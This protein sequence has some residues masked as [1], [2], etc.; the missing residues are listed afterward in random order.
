MKRLINLS[1]KFLAALI[2]TVTAAACVHQFPDE[3]TPADF[4]LKLKFNIEIG[5]NVN[6][7]MNTEINTGIG[8]GTKVSSETHDIRYIV[9]FFRLVNGEMAAEPAYEHTFTID[10]INIHTFEENLEI[11]EGHYRIYV[12]GDYVEQ[13][14]IDDHHYKTDGFPKIELMVSEDGGYEGSMESRDAYVGYTDIDVVR[15]GSTEKPVEA[16]VDIHRPLAKFVVI[17]NDLE[18]F[19]TKITQERAAELRQQAVA[20][21]ITEEAAE[22]ALTK[23]VDLD[24]FDVRFHFMGDESTMYNAPVTFDVFADRPIATVPGLNFSSKIRETANSETGQMEAQLGFDY[25]FVNGSDTHTRVVVGVYNKDGEQVAMTPSIKIPL[26]R[27]QVTYVRGGF[28]M[29]NV[30][31]GIAVNP[32]FDGPDYNY[33]IN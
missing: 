26:K 17:S 12:W 25:I 24:E 3:T 29:H 16:F 30:E 28:L 32:G 31:S 6:M 20:G 2:L 18:E 21:L 15:Y 22:E 23:A 9:K 1:R 5:V 7:N 14:S 4:V 19:V 8:T 13:G 33:E 10:D 27:N 11:A